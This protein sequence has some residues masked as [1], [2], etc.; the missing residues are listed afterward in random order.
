MAKPKR[1]KPKKF[2]SPFLL[3]FAAIA[4]WGAMHEPASLTNPAVAGAWALASLTIGLLV[5]AAIAILAPL[6][7]LAVESLRLPSAMMNRPNQNEA[8]S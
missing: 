1:S 5:R 8:E 7:G 2:F 4:G 3:S 6:A